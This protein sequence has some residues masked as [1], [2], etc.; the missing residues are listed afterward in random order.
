MVQNPKYTLHSRRKTDTF[1]PLSDG[2]T[3]EPNNLRSMVRRF[4]RKVISANDVDGYREKGYRAFDPHLHTGF[5]YDTIPNARLHPINLY[6]AMTE[7]GFDFVTFTDHDAFLSH[8]LFD[9]EVKKQGKLI[10]GIELSIKPV[11]IGGERNTHTLHVNVFDIGQSELDN[12]NLLSQRGDYAGFLDYLRQN[13]IPFM[14]NHPAWWKRGEQANWKLLPLIINDF[15]VIEVFNR[16]HIRELNDVAFEIASELGKGIV[17]SSDSHCGVPR[18]ATLAPGK[19]FR[20]MWENIKC[21]NAVIVD[22][23][24]DVKAIATEFVSYIDMIRDMDRDL[25]PGKRTFVKSKFADVALYAHQFSDLLV[26]FEELIIRW[27]SIQ[28]K[29]GLSTIEH[30]LARIIISRQQK[31]YAMIRQSLG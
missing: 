10:S 16:Q 5:S 20:E 31:E 9:D 24:L 28:H 13:D 11:V 26:N 22:E 7:K 27:L 19:D 14:L 1:A 4:F 8:D 15:D 29:S 6:K 25:F 3:E 12:L 18:M 21:N 30:L 2:S 23:H 17:A